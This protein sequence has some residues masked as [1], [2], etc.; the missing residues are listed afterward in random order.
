M[1]SKT[2]DPALWIDKLKVINKRL[3]GIDSPFKKGDIEMMSHIMANLPVEYSKVV[4]MLKVSEI[5]SKTINNLRLAVSDMW[6]RTLEMKV[7]AKS[8]KQSLN[9]GHKKS[10]KKFKGICGYC[11]K[12]GHKKETCFKKRKKDGEKGGDNEANN[13]KGGGKPK[14]KNPNIIC[15]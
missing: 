7:E 8:A 6:K 5:A 1:I 3:G 11:G 14:V 15:F 9:T 4:T 10:W 13:S 2:E 12:Q